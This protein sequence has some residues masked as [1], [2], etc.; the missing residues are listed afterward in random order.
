[1][2][3]LKYDLPKSNEKSRIYIHKETNVLRSEHDFLAMTDSEKKQFEI[4]K[5]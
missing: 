5:R 4:L 3:K 2:E 1:M